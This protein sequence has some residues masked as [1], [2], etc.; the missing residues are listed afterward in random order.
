M[1]DGAIDAVRGRERDSSTELPGIASQPL[2][3]P[4]SSP[5]SFLL[6]HRV[7][8]K[9]MLLFIE[10]TALIARMP[11]LFSHNLLLLYKNENRSQS[12]CRIWIPRGQRQ[13]SDR[14]KMGAE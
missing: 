4:P 10:I 11:E 7:A 2:P 1:E 12:L 9:D 13:P 6:F 8:T 5:S 3:P 14:L